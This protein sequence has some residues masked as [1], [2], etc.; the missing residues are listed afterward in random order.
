MAR[1]GGSIEPKKAKI[2]TRRGITLLKLLNQGALETNCESLERQ[3]LK[4]RAS[5]SGPL[6]F[7]NFVYKKRG[8]K[9]KPLLPWLTTERPAAIFLSGLSVVL[10]SSH[11]SRLHGVRIFLVLGTSCL[12]ARKNN[13]LHVTVNTESIWMIHLLGSST[14]CPKSSFLYFISLYF[15]K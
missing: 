3:R 2:K 5:G 11:E 9:K 6:F 13:P 8:E 4:K 12:S 14:G 15:S 1:V 7:V 10:G